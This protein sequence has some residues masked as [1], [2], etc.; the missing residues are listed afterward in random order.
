MCDRGDARMGCAVA[1]APTAAR[2]GRIGA[3]VALRMLLMLLMLLILLMACPARTEQAAYAEQAPATPAPVAKAAR[4]D[5]P[6]AK[7]AV[8]QIAQ[9]RL[10]GGLAEGTAQGGLLADVSPRLGRLIERLDKAATDARVKGLLLTIESPDVGRARA[11]E[12]RAAIGR[13]RQAGKPVVACFV[14]G[15]PVHY[16]IA[17]ACDT[18]TIVPAATLE[19][20]GVR[21]EVMFFK[22]LL[23]R[24]G[25]AAEII[26]VGAFK[27]AGEPLT[28]TEMSP[29]LRAQY[30]AFVG[31]L[32]EQFVA[33]VAADRRLPVERVRQLVDTGVFTPEAAREAGLVDAVG[34]EDEAAAALATRIGGEPQLARDYG[35]RKVDTDFSGLTGLVRLMEVM[36]G[37]GPKA[38]G[39]KARKI[40][41]VHVVGEIREGR[42]AD[43][44][45]A[46]PAAGADTIIE[47]IRTAA[48][49]DTV[50]AIVLRIDSPGGSAL[51]SDLI[52]RE[53]QRCTK[54]VVA[55]LSDTAASGGYYI[56]VGA[57]R[58]VAAPGTLTG[59][60][61]VVGGK[62]AVG[63]AL[64]KV[65][66]RTDV[67]SRGRNAGWLS[68]QQPFTETERAAFLGTMQDIYRLFTSKVAAGRGLE[69]ETVN[70]LAEGR[71]FTGR[72]ALEAK[73][74]DRLG[75]LDDAIDE[76]RSLAKIGADERLDRLLLP[77][78]RGFLEDLF[79]STGAAGDPVASLLLARAAGVPVLEEAVRGTQGLRQVL[80]GRPQLLPPARI[81]VR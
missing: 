23:D 29:A 9:I 71:V 8:A 12:I 68:P 39:G 50:V 17:T 7:K 15:T 55:S 66:V 43:D 38:G 65:G 54:P 57:D 1:P 75:T 56:A 44:L 49:D 2:R 37:S 31:D 80:S 51:A 81:T 35:K 22:G 72:M 26:Q 5:R 78:P 21:A 20:T 45:L 11:D 77:E 63:G 48:E 53:A 18:V 52:W 16:Q 69:P 33:R 27:G 61:G 25:V 41:I 70:N 24:L 74:V 79:A 6:A 10:A 4:E 42:S 32:Y 30:E 67:V 73:L 58:I 60:I 14:A 40:A 28:R 47:A 59:S 46:V 3:G 62:I 34:Y 13:V 36:S 76:A 19:I 64:E